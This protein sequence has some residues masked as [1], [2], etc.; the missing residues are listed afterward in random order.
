MPFSREAF[1]P[2]LLSPTGLQASEFLPLLIPEFLR[3]PR[4][5]SVG[6]GW[7]FEPPC[8]LV[9]WEKVL[10]LQNTT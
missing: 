1:F 10:L 8:S 9:D 3:A 4:G 5:P 2:F 7:T 6:L